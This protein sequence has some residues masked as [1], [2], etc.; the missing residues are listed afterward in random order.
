MLAASP[1]V[2][3]ARPGRAVRSVALALAL[4]GGVLLGGAPGA[5]AHSEL[6]S[7]RPANASTHPALPARVTLEFSGALG[8]VLRVRVR[9]PEGGER[10]GR[11]RVAPGAPRVVV[12]LRGAD[13]A[14]RYRGTWA[15]LSADGHTQAG[16]FGFRVAPPARPRAREDTAGV[17]FPA[18][19]RELLSVLSSLLSPSSRGAAGAPPTPR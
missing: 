12:P 8:R 16:S 13:T 10:A 14:G 4:A 15:V 17:P 2:G 19:L 1:E 9:G 5:S 3:R 6:V 7:L 18:W 11:A